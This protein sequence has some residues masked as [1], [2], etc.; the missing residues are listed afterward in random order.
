MISHNLVVHIQLV[1]CMLR[2]VVGGE[3]IRFRAYHPTEMTCESAVDVVGCE[4]GIQLLMEGP[5]VL[6]RSAMRG[7]LHG[8]P[9]RNATFRTLVGAV[10]WMGHPY[11]LLQ[12]VMF[13][14]AHAAQ[15]TLGTMTRYLFVID[16]IL[17]ALHS[18]PADVATPDFMHRAVMC[19]KLCSKQARTFSCSCVTRKCVSSSLRLKNPFFALHPSSSHWKGFLRSPCTRSLCI[20]ISP[21]E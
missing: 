10:R 14:E 8:L 5:T 6:V 18:C 20:L 17:L 16:Q 11:M 7:Q 4:G 9:P 15:T 1:L 21:L 2:E 12:T 13:E 3:S 19:L